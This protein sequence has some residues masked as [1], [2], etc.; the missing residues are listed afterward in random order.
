MRRILCGQRSLPFLNSP[1]V[2]YGCGKFRQAQGIVGTSTGQD[3]AQD[4]VNYSEGMSG[5]ESLFPELSSTGRC[6]VVQL[7]GPCQGDLVL[8]AEHEGESPLIGLCAVKGNLQRRAPKKMSIPRTLCRHQDLAHD[9]P[10]AG[11]LTCR[12]SAVRQSLPASA[13]FTLVCVAS[14]PGLPVKSLGMERSESFYWQSGSLRLLSLLPYLYPSTV[15]DT[16]ELPWLENTDSSLGTQ[17]H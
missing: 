17:R 7:L 13:L 16:W 5:T 3:E 1:A 8:T 4:E 15:T 10:R 11:Q 6:E 12:G 14:V 2:Y 9:S